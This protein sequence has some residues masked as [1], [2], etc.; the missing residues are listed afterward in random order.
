MTTKMCSRC[1]LEKPINCFYLNSR[2]KY[3]TVC[4]ECGVIRCREWR[5][6]NPERA[7]ASYKA[8]KL[9]LKNEDPVSYRILKL[10]PSM[11]SRYPNKNIAKELTADDLRELYKKQNG[12]CY[13][14][15][16]PMKLTADKY[17]DLFLMS[18][19]RISSTEGYTKD[20]VV[21]CCWGMNVLKGPHTEKELMVALSSF[22]DGAKTMGRLDTT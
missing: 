12:K 21:L 3:A 17:R 5:A 20:N 10:L 18:I 11:S 7:K 2:Q 13:Y 4:K 19:D 15:G 22:Y 1:K 9:K 8:S 6:N 16:I 14:T